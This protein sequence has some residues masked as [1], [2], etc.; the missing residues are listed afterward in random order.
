MEIECLFRGGKMGDGPDEYEV[1]SWHGWY[2]HVSLSML[3]MV[4]LTVVL[5]EADKN[6]PTKKL[7]LPGAV[8]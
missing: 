4:F 3:V 2:R 8:D 5:V 1:R 7:H 6:R